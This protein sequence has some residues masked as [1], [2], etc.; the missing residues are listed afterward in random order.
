[1]L[2]SPLLIWALAI[3]A[4]VVECATEGDDAFRQ[5]CLSLNPA[6]LVRNSTLVRL[7][8]VAQ[9]TTVSLNDNVPS[10]NRPA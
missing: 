7:E 5:D 8:F 1:M 6:A 2:F 3:I 9:G 4:R 10:C